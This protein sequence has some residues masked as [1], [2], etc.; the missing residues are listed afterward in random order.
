MSVEGRAIALELELAHALTDSGICAYELFVGRAGRSVEV[1]QVKAAMGIHRISE[2]HLTK[3]IAMFSQWKQ[4]MIGQARDMDGRSEARYNEA[5]QSLKLLQNAK[6][7]AEG[8]NVD[9]NEDDLIEKEEQRQFKKTTKRL[10]RK[11][12]HSAL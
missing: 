2:E 12:R 4:K 1:E 6:R 3:A 10:M 7:R 8:D 5:K 9:K 11:K